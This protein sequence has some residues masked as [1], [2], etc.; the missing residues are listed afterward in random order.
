MR[1]NSVT[2]QPNFTTLSPDKVAFYYPANPQRTS[3]TGLTF[4]SG[5]INITSPAPPLIFLITDPVFLLRLTFL[6][7]F[8]DLEDLKDFMEVLL[9][10]L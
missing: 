2:N 1:M 6:E 7:R 10:R 3:W 9:L 8:E 4:P 5:N